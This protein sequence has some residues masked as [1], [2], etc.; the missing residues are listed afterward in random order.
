MGCRAGLSTEATP[1]TLT[2][3][4]RQGP[5]LLRLPTG[6]RSL[7]LRAAECGQVLGR[8]SCDAWRDSAMEHC[9][10]RGVEGLAQQRALPQA[11]VR[12][13]KEHSGACR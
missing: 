2:P 13:H 7:P 1:L 12:R 4:N 9:G 3:E 10:G 6:M 8:R 11:P 5:G